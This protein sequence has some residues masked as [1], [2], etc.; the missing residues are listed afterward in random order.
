MQDTENPYAAPTTKTHDVSSRA[1]GE[2]RKLFSPTQGGAGAF[3][4]GPLMGLYV[5]QSNFAALDEHAKR[6]QAITYGAVFVAGFLLLIPFLPDRIPGY[7][8]GLVY[9]FVTRSIIEKHQLN[10]QQ[11]TDSASYA[12]KSN[13]LV[14]GMGM[15]SA[16]IMVAIMV[17]VFFV[18]AT[19]G[20]IEPL[21]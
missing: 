17:L 14:F 4:F 19:L 10:K 6:M 11:I 16:L 15:L 3:V 12:F 18:Y 13:W 20:W 5:I 21:W 7:V 9:M 1:D 2:I 8:F